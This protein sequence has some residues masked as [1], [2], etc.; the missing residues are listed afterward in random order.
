MLDYLLKPGYGASL[1]LIKLEVGG[2]TNSTDGAEPNHMPTRDTVDRGQGYQWWLA[3]QAKARS[4]DIKLAGLD[5]GA[6][7]WIGGGNFWSQ[8]TIDYYLSW[9][10]C[11]A[12]VLAYAARGQAEFSEMAARPRRSA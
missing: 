5:W 10:D 8:D 2:D 11:A 9:F 1:Q 6:P 3:E 7:G 12:K 4:P